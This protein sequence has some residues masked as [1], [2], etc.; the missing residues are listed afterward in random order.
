M[1]EIQKTVIDGSAEILEIG[2]DSLLSDGILK[3]IPILGSFIKAASISKSVS[4][5]IYLKKTEK[6]ILK[7]HETDSAK[8]VDLIIKILD[9][10][11]KRIKIGENLVLLLDNYNN[12]EKPELLA[13]FF[14]LF[15]EEKISQEDFLRIGSAID[16]AFIDDLNLFISD[17]SN[18]EVKRNLVISGLV[19]VSRTGVN[20]GE[21]V[22]YSGV[23]I[24]RLGNEFLKIQQ[25]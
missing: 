2:V 11:K 6:F 12:L 18:N 20:V 14:V 3:E 5:Y 22:T 21:G 16:L 13:R 23:H 8:R 1:N 19:E 10:E 24:S 17:S 9:D 7:F 15:L 4:D 25:Q